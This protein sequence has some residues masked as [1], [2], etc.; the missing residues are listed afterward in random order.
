MAN[1]EGR[2]NRALPK[3]PRDL[4]YEIHTN[5][6]LEFM[7]KGIKPLAYFSDLIFDDSDMWEPD[8]P[9]EWQVELGRFVKHEVRELCEPYTHNG[10]L[11]K[12]EWSRFYALK[13]DAWRIP[14]FLL[15]KKLAHYFGE[16]LIHR[17][18]PGSFGERLP[19]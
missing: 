13:D 17:N 19:A 10:H 12:G 16:L 15:L 5:R 14:A 8:E 9:F 18:D 7:L 3:H 2:G 4:S 1:D 6:E 11:I